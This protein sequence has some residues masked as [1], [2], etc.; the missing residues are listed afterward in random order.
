MRIG[1]LHLFVLATLVSV[2]A[3]GPSVAQAPPTIEAELNRY[4]VPVT[5]LGLRSALRDNRPEVGR[6]LAAGELA[7]IKDTSS[8]PL[9]LKT[10][11]AEK[12]PSVRFNMATALV[13]LNSQVGNRVLAH[14]CDDAHRCQ[15]SVA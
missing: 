11:E 2:V 12:D 7:E 6:S 10:L 14:M 4:G 9:I 3:C 15:K 5:Q 8:V 13:S 1:V